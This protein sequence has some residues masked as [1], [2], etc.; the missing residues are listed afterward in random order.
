MPM[1]WRFWINM[2]T[3]VLKSKIFIIIQPSAPKSSKARK[4]FF[5][6][7]IFHDYFWTMLSKKKPKI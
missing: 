4:L 1:L 6:S 7:L 3:S 5:V 2:I